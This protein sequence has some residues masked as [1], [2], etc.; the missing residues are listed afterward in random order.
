MDTHPPQHSLKVAENCTIKQIGISSL[1][2]LLLLFWLKKM[3]TFYGYK[4]RTAS[5]LP[6]EHKLGLLLMNGLLSPPFWHP[7]CARLH[8]ST[9][10]HTSFPDHFHCSRLPP[11]CHRQKAPLPLQ[12]TKGDIPCPVAGLLSCLCKSSWITTTEQQRD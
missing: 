8:S 9:V 10:Q 11:H 3:L 12:S 6:T 7:L 2:L 1:L 4:S 5:S